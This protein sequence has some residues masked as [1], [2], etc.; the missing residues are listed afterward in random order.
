VDHPFHIFWRS[1]GPFAAR[2]RPL[3]S[4]RRAGYPRADDRRR[5]LPPTRHLPHPRV[6]VGSPLFCEARRRTVTVTGFSP[7][8]IPW[9]VGRTCTRPT[10]IVCGGLVGAV[11]RERVEAVAWGWGV[12]RQT[13]AKWRRVL[14][15]GTSKWRR[16]EISETGR[17]HDAERVGL[18]PGR[19]RG[20]ADAPARG[21]RP[22][23]RPA[24]R[25]GVRAAV[26]AGGGPPAGEP[27]SVRSPDAVRREGHPAQWRGPRVSRRPGWPRGGQQPAHGGGMTSPRL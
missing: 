7:G 6:R 3:A 8:P 20:G 5:P 19:G 13:V 18:E 22:A 12:T 14:D 23:D 26:H 21:G 10:L 24:D 1:L 25:S 9:P 11:R 17:G 16:E 4:P 15:V 2:G 27:G